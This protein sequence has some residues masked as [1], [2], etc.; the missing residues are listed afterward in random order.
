M[1]CV[2]TPSTPAET[3]I[4]IMV[5]NAAFDRYRNDYYGMNV[6]KVGYD[7][8]YLADMKFLL[9]YTQCAGQACVCYCNCSAE[10]IKE[11]IQTL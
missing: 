4:D 3:K 10:Q 1:S 8:A 11:K 7:Y 2:I 6:C 9:E 5:S